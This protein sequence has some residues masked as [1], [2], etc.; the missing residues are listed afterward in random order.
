MA[1]TS[2]PISWGCISRARTRGIAATRLRSCATAAVHS[3]TRPKRH[4]QSRGGRVCRPR[5]T[6]QRH[7]SDVLIVGGG[8]TAA[9]VAQKLF[10]RRP[11]WSITVVEAG[12]RL[13]DFENRNEYRE[14]SL[15]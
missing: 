13:F 7:E 10:E 12:K 9:L 4:P 5:V 6:L 1:R 11:A 2:S 8:I 15:N 3:T 14:R